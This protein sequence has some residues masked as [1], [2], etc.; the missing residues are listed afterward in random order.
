MVISS[1]LYIFLLFVE[2]TFRWQLLLS[3]TYIFLIVSPMKVVKRCFILE[4]FHL[5]RK[6]IK[7][8]LYREIE[9]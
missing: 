9:E 8:R 1:L 7:E 3:L 5:S 6:I 4:Y 2:K